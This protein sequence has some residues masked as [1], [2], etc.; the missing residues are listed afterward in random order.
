MFYFCNYLPMVLAEHPQIQFHIYYDEQHAPLGLTTRRCP[1]TAF[2]FFILDNTSAIHHRNN[3]VW[4]VCLF[5]I[6]LEMPL[7]LI[8]Y[9]LTFI[10]N[11]NAVSVQKLLELYVHLNVPHLVQFTISWRPRRF[12]SFLT[13][14][15][16]Q[17]VGK[18]ET[19]ATIRTSHPQE[20]KKKGRSPN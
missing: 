17:K 4:E 8:L 18:C 12:L 2:F 15:K 14:E 16:V 9:L 13:S 1:N 7:G 5:F 6:S 10:C 11:H 20:R 19:S 3:S